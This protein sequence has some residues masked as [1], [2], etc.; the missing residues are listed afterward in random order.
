VSEI[1]RI[2][3]IVPCYNEEESLPFL[4]TAFE[5]VKKHLP[6]NFTLDL[7]LINDGSQ[8]KTQ[9][10]V[11]KLSKE[12]N[13]LYYRSFAGNYGHQSALRAGINASC[14][15]DAAV[16]MDADL[17]HPPELI[18]QMVEEWLKGTKIV[19]MVRNDG[20]KEVGAIKYLTSKGYY[21]FINSI[22]GLNLEYGASDFRLID[23]SIIKTVAESHEKDLFLRGYFSWL[24]VSRKTISYKP[25][26][27]IAGTSKYTFKKML[28]LA[29]TG[30][31][32]FSEKPLRM[33]MS[34]GAA[35]AFLSVVYGVVLV[36]RYLVGDMAVSGWTSLMV[37]L[38]F[39]FGVNFIL[40]GIM[41]SYLAHSISI[42]KQRP[43]YIVSDEKLAKLS[44]S[45]S[46]KS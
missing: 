22:T 27:R 12:K 21:K 45:T 8:D 34:L 10:I 15:Y 14:D 6:K 37:V 25:N 18:I 39:C 40:L 3:V 1:K 31:L 23:K 9:E 42:Q 24:K 28:K 16:M 41:G 44:H 35:M 20:A 33:A 43:D 30:V 29:G 5:G 19:Q 7:L 32:Q 26:K 36:V 17:Q 11:E 4:I 46:Y 2:V 13:Y 38:L